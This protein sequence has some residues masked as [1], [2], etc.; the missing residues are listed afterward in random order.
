VPIPSFLQP[1]QN[2]APPPLAAPAAALGG[3]V[4]ASGSLTGFVVQ[5]QE[6][7]QWCWAAVSTSVAI[8]FGSKKWTQCRVASGELDPLNCCGVDRSTGCN[9][10]WYLDTALTRVGHF[11]RIDASS[12]PFSDVQTEVNGKRPLGC[13]IAWAGGSAHFVAIG[14]WSTAADG[15]EYVDV[16]DPY[17]GFTQKTY[18]DFVSAY[19]TTGDTWTHSYFTRATAAALAGA[20]APSANSPK[21]A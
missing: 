14:G 15:T 10:P 13:R 20:P 19:R 16:Y 5:T 3:A 6:E 17:Y 2:L 7:A 4:P 12:A 11:D 8:F 9:I 1:L 18:G 21:S